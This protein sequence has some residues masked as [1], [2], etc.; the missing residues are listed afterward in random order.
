[1]RS[2]AREMNAPRRAVALCVSC[3][4]SGAHSWCFCFRTNPFASHSIHSPSHLLV[5]RLS[6]SV[7]EACAPPTL[8]APR[9]CSGRA[10]TASTAPPVASR[11]PDCVL[12]R[13]PT[14]PT[15]SGRL[16]CFEPLCV[17]PTQ[18]Q[19]C[20]WP[21]P[22]SSFPPSY[23]A[24]CSLGIECARS[25]GRTR[26]RCNASAQTTLSA[27]TG[28]GPTPACE[29]RRSL[30]TNTLLQRL[31]K[32]RNHTQTSVTVTLIFDLL[33]ISVV[34]SPAT[35]HFSD[36]CAVV[37]VRLCAA[38]VRSCARSSAAERRRHPKHAFV[39][40]RVACAA[41]VSRG[42]SGVED[43]AVR[44]PNAARLPHEQRVF[45]MQRDGS[46][47][48][49]ERDRPAASVLFDSRSFRFGRRNHTGW[50]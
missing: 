49:S 41:K 32:V 50:F 12:R 11:S 34:C 16:R 19:T 40:R 23:A 30:H 44:P 31:H 21:Q 38:P 22:L 36:V 5:T 35:H 14:R 27:T 28:T 3:L 4:E 20:E 24:A 9:R 25:A 46:P 6:S 39:A 18:H 29:K 42:L 48:H 1:M 33:E 10:R 2:H 37:L 45:C 15:A 17:S 43:A 26:A 13:A 47:R 7:P 8:L